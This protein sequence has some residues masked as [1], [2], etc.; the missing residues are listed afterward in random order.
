MEGLGASPTVKVV[1]YT[2]IGILATIET[3]VYCRWAWYKLFPKTQPGKEGE[4]RV[5]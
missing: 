2:A 5:G 1:V 3:Y 4:E